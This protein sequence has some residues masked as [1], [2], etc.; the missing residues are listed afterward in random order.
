M[1]RGALVTTVARVAGASAFAAAVPVAVTAPVRL[2]PLAK[3][4]PAL[5]EEVRLYVLPEPGLKSKVA[6][7]PVLIPEALLSRQLRLLL[8]LL[9]PGTLGGRHRAT[10]NEAPGLSS[11]LAH[12]RLGTALVADLH[13]LK[14]TSKRSEVRERLRNGKEPFLTIAG[15]LTLGEGITTIF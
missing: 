3:R 14:S 2:V 4:G 1:L 9:L 11:L 13:A 6:L 5:R 7:A 10:L 8:L 15:S 12:L